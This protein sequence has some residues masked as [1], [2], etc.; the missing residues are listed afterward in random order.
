MPPDNRGK[1]Y[2][3][4]NPIP[5]LDQFNDNSIFPSPVQRVLFKW[6]FFWSLFFIH[7]P[8]TST[9]QSLFRS[10]NSAVECLGR[11]NQLQSAAQQDF[12]LLKQLS[13]GFS[14]TQWWLLLLLLKSNRSSITYTSINLSK[15]KLGAGV[16]SFCPPSKLI[17]FSFWNP[18]VGREISLGKKSRMACF[19]WRGGNKGK[20]SGRQ[21]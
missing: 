6:V 7:W 19:R 18:K 15:L 17:I 11:E 16:G 5:L 9:A 4:L 14:G 20:Y 12:P 1:R 10:V 8:A 2:F 13:S 21:R 3:P